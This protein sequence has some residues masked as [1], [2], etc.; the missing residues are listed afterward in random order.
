LKLKETGYVQR[1]G[2]EA[3][4]RTLVASAPTCGKNALPVVEGDLEVVEIKSGRNARLVAK[5]K[6][7]Y[8]LLISR[9]VPIRIVRVKIVSF[10]MNSFLVE[11]TKVES[12]L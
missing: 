10:D 4:Q 2:R 3:C 11:A 6:E 9:D 1:A 7:A 12:L 8:N 5:Q